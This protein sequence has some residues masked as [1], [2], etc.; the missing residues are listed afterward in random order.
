[1]NYYMEWEGEK[2]LPSPL[3]TVP[4]LL[5][6]YPGE[7]TCTVCGQTFHEGFRGCPRCA[8]D[9]DG[10]NFDEHGVKSY[11]QTRTVPTTSYLRE[12]EY[13]VIS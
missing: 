9:T 8:N 10:W 11:V 4:Y 2:V 13:Y 5:K 6:V 12:D 7:V 1:M 3:Y